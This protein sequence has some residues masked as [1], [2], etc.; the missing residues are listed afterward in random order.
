MLVD[1]KVS[2]LSTSPCYHNL[3]KFHH[4]VPSVQKIRDPGMDIYNSVQKSPY[5]DQRESP[6]RHWRVDPGEGGVPELEIVERVDV[7]AVAGNPYVL[8]A[9]FTG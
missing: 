8:H 2:A 5:E 3:T 4:V 6:R 9:S 7:I 1:L